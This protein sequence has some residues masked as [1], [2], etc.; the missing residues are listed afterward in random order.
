MTA[1]GANSLNTGE[2]V[3][4]SLVRSDDAALSGPLT[5]EAGTGTVTVHTYTAAV[6]L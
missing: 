3:T 1:N 4:W 2:S 6:A 5:I